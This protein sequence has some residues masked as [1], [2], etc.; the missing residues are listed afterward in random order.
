MVEW[1]A[2]LIERVSGY[3]ARQGEALLRRLL[4]LV[5][6]I[7][8]LLVG[9]VIVAYEAIF[10][11]QSGL[12]TL[13]I[14]D[15]APSNI[16]ATET[17]SYIS[18][19]LTRQRREEARRG[20]PDIYT[21]PDA[22]VARTQSALAARILE[23]IDNVRQDV[24]GS[25]EE[26]RRDI[27]A[28]TSLD[29]NDAIIEPI[30]TMDDEKWRAID[31]EVRALL[32][33]VMQES[34][35]EVDLQ[36]FIDR[37]PNQVSLR[38]NEQE[39]QVVVELVRDLVRPNRT[40]NSDATLAARDAAATNV[41]D[42]EVIFQRGQIIVSGGAVV[43]PT[44]YEALTELGLLQP[45]SLR[46]QSI[47]RAL[48]A[49]LVV[50]VILG[51]YMLRFHASLVHTETRLI[52]LMALIFLVALLAGRL[53]I[54]G[55]IYLFASG[56]AG[57]L[58]AALVAPSIAVLASMG[59]AMLI[60]IM[61]NDSLEVTVNVAVASMVGILTL[62]RPERLT[63]FFASGLLMSVGSIAVVII[64]NI[65]S[66][67]ET[68]AEN[69]ALSVM[70][71]L[72]SGI[73]AAAASILG[74][75]LIGQVFNFA[76]A[77]RL[78]EL[79]QPSQP[80]LQRLLRDA[81]GTY[82]H[83]LQVANLAEQAASA[84]GADAA[85]VRVAAL[86]HD[87]GKL[88]NP[89]F[90]V[91]NQPEIGHSPH[92]ALND[93]YASAAIIIDHVVR[94]AEMAKRNHLPRRIRDF[95]LEH[96]GTTQVYVFYQR[97]I[98][99]K[100]ADEPTVDPADFSYPG[101]KPQTRETAILLLAD[102]SEASVRSMRPESREQIESIVETIFEG[103]RKEGQL[104]ECDITLK[105][106]SIIKTVFV[107]LLKA[108]YHPRI[109]YQEAL[110]LSRRLQETPDSGDGSAAPQATPEVSAPPVSSVQTQTS[111]RV[112]PSSPVTHSPR[113]QSSRKRNA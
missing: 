89:A 76:T 57:L 19:V 52:V 17:R 24:Y 21:P 113:S 50:M 87:I 99:Q 55:Q 28:I 111:G 18:D 90:F 13:E 40:V 94:G 37:L 100:A 81:P 97:A 27:Q 104:D 56:I 75:Y 46:F 86:Y 48:V 70:Y 106:L 49:V 79:N 22:A 95:I 68:R 9:T 67:S 30:I 33:Q 35:R 8:F 61:A 98:A 43:D 63:S 38:F 1:F 96:H 82:Q 62:R 83:S 45:A 39:V 12:S 78:I 47:L 7:S 20:V 60:G 74:L 58:Y 93:P 34:I 92:D 26:K 23:Y 105:E 5:A 91:E 110:T 109:N 101:P 54:G 2:S 102:S 6:V 36:G 84:I 16:Y 108:M 88:L 51:L 59:L 64:F 4:L 85:L 15:P 3:P 41:P 25:F 11:A 32:E 65:A 10:G 77:V 66:P 73:I 107:D 44:V 80:L 31:A 69:I 72:F 53:G 42:Q 14:G 71:A 29:L 112:E 103:K